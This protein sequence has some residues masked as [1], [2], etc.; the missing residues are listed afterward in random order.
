LE[1]YDV[2]IIGGGSTGLAALRRLSK[3][4]KQAILL[5]AGSHQVRSE[6]DS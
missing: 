4:G 1:K 3:L 2:G 5:E 6:I